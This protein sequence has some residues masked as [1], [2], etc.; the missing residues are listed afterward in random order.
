MKINNQFYDELGNDWIDRI[1]HPVA[2]LRAENALRAPWIA[3]EIKY[4]IE[5]P[6]KILDVG[7]GAGFLTNHLAQQQHQVTGIDLSESS[8]E[9]AKRTERTIERS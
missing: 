1:D 6:A 2:L 8:L 5:K 9:I 3:E 4:R 7:C